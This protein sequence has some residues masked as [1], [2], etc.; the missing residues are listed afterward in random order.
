M[1]KH[2]S[3]DE[4][5]FLCELVVKYG[6]ALTK[7]AYRFFNYQPHMY[8]AAQDAVQET[9]V[10]AV[11]DVEILMNHPSKIGWLKVSLRNILLNMVNRNQYWQH[12]ELQDEIKENPFEQQQAILDALDYLEGYPR[13]SEVIAVADTILTPDENE[14]FTDHFLFGYTT[15]ETAAREKISNDTVRGRLSRIRKKLRKYFGFSCF[16]LL[17]MFYKVWGGRIV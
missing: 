1:K 9:F 14:T 4:S 10:K 12:E 7:Y 8:E 2:L 16:F 6:D 15:E 11:R 17:V 5:A 13:L 3:Y